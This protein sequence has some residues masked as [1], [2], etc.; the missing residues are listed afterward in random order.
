ML[1]NEHDPPQEGSF[2][3][4][5]G[6]AIKPDTVADFNHHVGC[7]DKGDRMTN[8]DSIS[9]TW[10]WMKTLFLCLLDLVILNSYILLS[11]WWEENFTQKFQPTLLRNVLAGFDKNG[12]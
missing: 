2:H 4:E 8:S 9:Q 12:R 3:C 5:Q 1:T 7:I 6:N 10:K 11:S